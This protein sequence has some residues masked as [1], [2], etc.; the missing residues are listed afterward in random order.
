MVHRRWSWSVSF[1]GGLAALAA[2]G[3][4][5]TGQPPVEPDVPCLPV[6]DG[7]A[8]TEDLCEEG[9]PVHRPICPTGADHTYVISE[10]VLPS[11]STQATALGL[12]IDDK[13]NDGIDNQLG[14]L[15]ASLETLA[16]GFN[17]GG[18]QAGAIDRGETILLVNVKATALDAAEAVGLTLYPGI[19]PR[20]AACNGPTD[21]TCR[22]HLDGTAS[23]DVASAPSGQGVVGAI[24]AGR[25]HGGPGVLTLSLTFGV[26]GIPIEVPLQLAKA[27]LAVTVAGFAPGSKLGG[28]ITDADLDLR[29]LPGIHASFSEIVDRD[30]PQPRTGPTCNCD[31][32]SSGRQVLGLL[33]FNDDC[34]ITLGEVRDTFNG[35]L[36]RDIDLDEDGANDAVSVGVGVRAVPATFTVPAF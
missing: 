35:L 16:P 25:Y 22:R 30:C 2:C 23:F 8:C 7:D 31:D 18:G 27:E 33:D 29:V 4:G 34:T 24:T 14:N 20:P 1:I 36:T 10:L 21:T 17:L 26:G 5:G 6:D 12:D 13:P 32:G 15:L 19:N 11:S 3:G 9:V 28:A